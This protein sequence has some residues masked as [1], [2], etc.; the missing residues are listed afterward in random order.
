MKSYMKNQVW[1]PLSYV[2]GTENR[3]LVFAKIFNSE[4][5]HYLFKLI[6]SRSCGYVTR[7]MHKIPPFKTR[8]TFLKKLFLC[9]FPST[10]IR[11]EYTRSQHI[12]FQQLQYFQENILTFSRSSANSFFNSHDIKAIKLIAKLQLGLSHSREHKF[13]HGFQDSLNPLL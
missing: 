11:G 10:I 8:H 1:T 5:L 13:N 7:N 12:K 2:L 9:F 6:P 4:H 3:D